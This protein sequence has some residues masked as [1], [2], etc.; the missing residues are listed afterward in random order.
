MAAG[1]GRKITVVLVVVLVLLLGGLL[2][3][4]RIGA[5]E[6]EQAIAKQ[7][8]QELTA[9]QITSPS[10][11]KV[12][13]DGFPFL[14]QVAAGVY[15]KIT[16]KVDK[17]STQG[18]TLDRFDV[19]ARRVHAKT[20]DVLNGTGTVTAEQ[21]NGVGQVPWNQV[22][23]LITLTGVDASN[24]AVTADDQGRITAEI[25]VN[26]LGLQTT[27]VATGSVTVQNGSA[28]VT[29]DKITTK[30]GAQSPLINT[31]LAQLKQALKVQV[32]LPR[33][34]YNLEVTGV[35][36]THT[37]LQVTALAKNVVMS[38]ANG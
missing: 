8:S 19:V 25:P 4:D 32:K 9:R 7:A 13:I 21:V 5:H 34:P 31:L 29:V 11:P 20:S 24:V 17:P 10:K 14:T 16:I 6:A 28:Q 15:Q 12:H 27:V 33:L 30:G 3:A 37:G 18:V 23:K 35:Q 1:R 38:G 26:T 2:A 22:G 36:A